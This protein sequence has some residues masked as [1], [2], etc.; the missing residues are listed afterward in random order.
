MRILFDC[1]YVRFGR[2]DGISRYS[3]RLVEELAKLHP[4][5]MVIYDERQLE[6]LPDLPWVKGTHP[7][8]LAEPLGSLFL[9]RYHPDV[10][11][12]PMQTIGPWGRKFALVTTVHDVIY[13][14]Y[15][16]PPRTI[17]AFARLVWRGYHLWWGFQ[18]G[19]LRKADAHLTDSETT[20]QLMADHRATPNP[21][22]VVYLGA[23][24]PPGPV[25]R[26]LPA[27][28]ELV[29]MGSFM[30]YK[31]VDLLARALHRLPGYRLT[32]MSAVSARE[33]AALERIAP[34]GALHF[35]NGATDEEYEAALD[36]AT[37]IVSASLGEG[38]GLPVIEGMS[39]GTPA[40][41]RDL[42]I[43]REIGGGAARY[44][45]DEDGL[46]AEL[47]ALENAGEWERRS[48]ESVQ[49]AGSFTWERAA[50]QLLAV[51]VATTERRASPRTA[52]GA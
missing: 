21:V 16:T 44:F 4:V 11:F 41:V 3:S 32:L 6:L 34:A 15:R 39:R 7:R 45:D 33:R 25:Q 49:H 50:E 28:H 17:N 31:G 29:Y 37:A 8:G 43:F 12:T 19:L 1:R 48:A 20:K 14:E 9:N 23:D 47:R 24:G 13:Y 27:E 10:V 46:V 5:T 36:R 38:F 18:R 2:H 42:P 40:V 30:E 35:L 51:L 22:T 52:S 26:A